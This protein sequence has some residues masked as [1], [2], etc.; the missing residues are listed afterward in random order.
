MLYEG[1][2]CGYV[3]IENHEVDVVNFILSGDYNKNLTF[4][5][6][7]GLKDKNGREIYEGDIMKVEHGKGVVKFVEFGWGIMF[8]E[9]FGE[10]FMN[11]CSYNLDEKLYIYVDE[12]SV[13]GNIYENPELL[14][15]K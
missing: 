11:Y 3:D 5:Q 15:E 12:F 1:E 7:T 2:S 13:V 14:T 8:E 4:M 10:P 6:Y 9:N